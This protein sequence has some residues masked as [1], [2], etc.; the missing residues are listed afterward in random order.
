[1]QLHSPLL[2]LSSCIILSS[3]FIINSANAQITSDTTLGGESSIISPNKV[4]NGEQVDLIEGGAVRDTNLF[5]SF[6]EFNISNGQKVFFA[7]PDT[8]VN[9]FSRITGNNPS[10]ILGKL[11]VNGN[12]NLFLIN[13]NGILFGENASLDVNGSFLAST[14]ESI[15]FSDGTQFNTTD[16]QT[17][18]LLTVSIPVGLNMGATS[19]KIMN[20]SFFQDIGLQVPLEKTLALIGGD[21]V[22]EGGFLT[23]EAGNIELGSVAANNKIGLTVTE[24]NL[25]ISYE[26]INE[27]KNL[28]LSQGAFVFLDTFEGSGD[29]IQIQGKQINITDG[30]QI[31]TAS[32]GDG[33]G[34]N[35]IVR[36]SETLTISGEINLGESIFV[37]GL[38]ADVYS[39]GNGGNILVEVQQLVINSG[40]EIAASTFSD[41]NSGNL[42]INASESI[43]IVGTG[44]RDQASPSG[45]LAQVINSAKGNAGNLKIDTKQLI[46]EGGANISSPT[47]GEGNAG[48]LTINVS[49]LIA[50]KGT[51][52]GTNNP[53]VITTQVEEG[54]T[55]NAGNLTINTRQ[56][57]ILNGAQVSNAVRNGG[58]AADLNITAKDS[59]LISGT[60]TSP[61]PTLTEGSSG[62]F[63]S[64]EP[65]FEDESGNLVVT[66]A[67]AGRL[68]ITTS[69]LTV[70]NGAKISADNFGTGQGGNATFNVDNLIIKNGGLVRAGSFGKGQGGTLTVNATESV[71]ITGTGFIGD[72]TVNS[73]LFT[74]AEGTGDAGDLFINKS[75]NLIVSNGGEIT[76]Q[77][78]GTGEGGDIIA[79]T[80]EITLNQ[81]SITASTASNQGGNITLNID[82]NLN[83]VNR[84]EITASAGTAQ[85][86]GNGGNVIINSDFIFAFPTDNP[87]QITAQAFTGDGGRIDLTTNSIFGREYINID[88]SSQAGGIDG[89]IAINTPDVNPVQG[90]TNLPINVVDPSQLVSQ[91]CF[92]GE[93]AGKSSSFTVTGKG[94][95]PP[96]PNDSLKGNATIAPE[97][98]AINSLETENT[99][100]TK[101]KTN[102]ESPAA[103]LP[104]IVQAR[105]WVRDKNGRLT[106]VA[107]NPYEMA[108][109]SS[110]GYLGCQ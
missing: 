104:Q 29:K 59:I 28:T 89:T 79:T 25:A 50:I 75:P 65:P 83:L 76:A 73:S 97:W 8:V 27:F 20:R 12:A 100:N 85:A 71:E 17:E 22:I 82:N 38:F 61:T 44:G 13:P 107:E 95:L 78:S 52:I 42:T 70:E 5:H 63:V 51:A 66:T 56:L 86:G 109:G 43:E 101:V 54:A 57:N 62:I 24:N 69:T 81:G 90:L 58:K 35:L 26:G 6:V 10:E 74:Q 49:D 91:S 3:C 45:I 36:A 102:Q 92:A 64:A 72:T 32:S 53:T 7:N 77:S 93:T 11:G 60:R 80:K 30:S 16:T 9:I 33:R 68:N 103:K 31:L 41:G 98:L 21:V 84:G 4:I 34:G 96:S 99:E 2:N 14:A 87:Y 88:A 39:V 105:G 67:D 47:F 46:L 23:A 18:P 37:S 108:S 40:G 15:N 106:L 55:G 48:N 110:V 1:M 94:G 19:S